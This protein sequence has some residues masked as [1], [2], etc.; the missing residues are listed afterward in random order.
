MLCNALFRLLHRDVENAARFVLDGVHGRVADAAV[1]RQR[2][3]EERVLGVVLV[4]DGAHLFAHAVVGD[5]LVGELGRL[6]E[7]VLRAGREIL[8]R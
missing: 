3:P 4:V 2:L 6:L 7:V 1:G 5:H 8:R